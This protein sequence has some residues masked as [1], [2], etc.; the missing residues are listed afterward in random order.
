MPRK[1]RKAE[2]LR[3]VLTQQSEKPGH[4]WLTSVIPATWEADIRRIMVHGQVGRIV[5]KTSF[6][7]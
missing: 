3:A 2:N 6:P 5:L 4:L 1:P 7:K